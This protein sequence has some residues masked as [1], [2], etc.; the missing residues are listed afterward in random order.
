MRSRARRPVPRYP[1]GKT[2]RGGNKSGGA[3]AMI[4]T[5]EHTTHDRA[6]GS[7][8]RPSARRP[9]AGGSMRRRG[10]T[11][12]D[13]AAALPGRPHA[14]PAATA[15]TRKRAVV[16]PKVRA[17]QSPPQPRQAGGEVVRDGGRA[18]AYRRRRRRVSRVPWRRPQEKGHAKEIG[19]H[20]ARRRGHGGRTPRQWY[21]RRAR[22][23]PRRGAA[24][25]GTGCARPG[26][27]GRCTSTRPGRS[28]S[29]ERRRGRR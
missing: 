7:R 17:A 6:G 14:P 10:G 22:A 2:E 4:R 18:P 26:Y 23:R 3:H 29:V 16:L 25:C 28:R 19:R 11:A 1:P 21:G 15:S 13:A 8:A 24:A 12:R 27:R 20:T 9:R 5:D